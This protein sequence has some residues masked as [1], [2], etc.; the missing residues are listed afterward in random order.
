ME[1]VARLFMNNNDKNNN[2][3]TLVC[4]YFCMIVTFNL[5]SLILFILKLA[6]FSCCVFAWEHIWL[7]LPKLITFHHFL[8]YSCSEM[9][10]SSIYTFAQKS[11]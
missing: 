2:W 3:I 5:C 4:V 9:L 10:Q 8:L 7:E 11:G 6:L 1:I